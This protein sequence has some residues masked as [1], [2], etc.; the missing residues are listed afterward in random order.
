MKKSSSILL[1]AVCLFSLSIGFSSC[2]STE[3][4]YHWDK[5]ENASYAYTKEP[6]EKN[7]NNLAKCYDKMFEKQ[8]KSYRKVVPPGLC[9]EKAYMLLKAGNKEE[10]M[11]YFDLEIKY[12]PESK[13]FIDRIKKQIGQ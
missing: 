10:A 4:L 7:L 6:N 8:G 13:L 3:T 2:V 5:Y 11:K 9:A 12:Y 1:G